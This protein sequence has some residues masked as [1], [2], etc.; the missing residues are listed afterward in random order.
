MADSTL[1]DLIGK[2]ATPSKVKDEP[3]VKKQRTKK[4]DT[5]EAT[6]DVA[7]WKEGGVIRTEWLKRDR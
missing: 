3:G 7:A 6:E 1:Q 4:S 2:L 5:G